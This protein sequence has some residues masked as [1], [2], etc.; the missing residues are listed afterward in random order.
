DFATWVPLE[1]DRPVM[2]VCWY[3]AEAYCR[4]ARRRLPAE[5]EWELAAAAGPNEGRP[6]LSAVKRRYPWDD[7]PPDPGRANLDGAMLGCVDVAACSA[8]DSAWGC[9]QMLGNVWEWTAGDFGPYPGFAVDPYPGYSQPCFGTHKVLRGGGWLTRARLVRN[10]WR[11][12]SRP[13][14]REGWVGFRTCAL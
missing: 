6:G 12:F 14:W 11:G 4:W 1:P 7:Q 8:G 2:H 9:R 3:E 10:T 13:D 5:A